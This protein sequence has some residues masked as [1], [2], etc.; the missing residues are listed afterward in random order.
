MNTITKKTKRIEMPKTF[1]TKKVNMIDF[2]KNHLNISVSFRQIIDI[3]SQLSPSE[4]RQLS[5]VLFEELNIDDIVIPE[6]HKQIV[7]ERIKKYEDNPESYLSWENMYV[8]L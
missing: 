3:V 6:K 8:C 2:Q 5:E 4:K 7:R 1:T